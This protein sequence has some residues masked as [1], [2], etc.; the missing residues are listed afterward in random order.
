MGVGDPI[1]L[2]TG[3]TGRQKPNDGVLARPLGYPKEVADE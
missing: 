2:T 1:E 3:S